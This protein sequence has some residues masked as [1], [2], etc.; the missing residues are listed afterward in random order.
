MYYKVAQ[1]QKIIFKRYLS[2]IKLFV[3]MVNSHKM[4]KI[5]F[6]NKTIAGLHF[7]YNA[8]CVFLKLLVKIKTPDT[9]Q[10]SCQITNKTRE[11]SRAKH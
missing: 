6:R 2:V 11:L 5:A 9:S 3:N 8:S 4:E 10:V 1:H 7:F